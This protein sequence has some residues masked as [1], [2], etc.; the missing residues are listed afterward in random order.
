MKLSNHATAAYLISLLVS[1]LVN[2]V[3]GALL[4]RKVE[5]NQMA[6]KQSQMAA[7]NAQASA[8]VAETLFQ[9]RATQWE[10]METLAT[11][12]HATGLPVRC[13]GRRGHRTCV[14]ILPPPVIAE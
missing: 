11:Q 14:V 12:L 5:Q 8:F 4:H 1:V 2:G 13:T 10:A 7:T 9:H 6:V 3:W